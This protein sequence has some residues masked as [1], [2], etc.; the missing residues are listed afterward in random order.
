MKKYLLL[1]LLPFVIYPSNPNEGKKLILKMANS[2]IIIDGIIDNEWSSADSVVNFFQLQP[3]YNQPPSHSTVAKVL[4]TEDAIYCLMICYQQ[5]EDIQANS[6]SLDENTGDIVSF[7]IDSFNDQQ[8]AYKFAVNASGVRMDSRLL[9]DARNRDYSWD[10]I[11]FADSKIYNWGY[12][13]EMK[14]PYKSIKYE[15]NLSEWG[16]DFDRWIPAQNEDLYWC[17]YEQN[18]GQRI[19]KF[20]KLVFENFQPTATG[21]NLEIYPVGLMKVNYQGN[22]KYKVEPDA[23]LDIF[24]NPSQKLT[25]Q[26]TV[27]PDFAQI[28]ADPFDFN[29]SRYESYFNERR[30]FFTEGNEVF[31][32]SGR[33]RNTGFYRP[34][35]LFYSRRIGKLLPDGKRIPLILGTKAFGRVDDWEY[36]GFVAMTS[37]VNYRD[38][39]EE[40]V[41]P[42]AYFGSGRIKKQV[43]GNSSIGLLFVAKQTEDNTYGVID[44]DGAFRESNWQLSYQFARSIENSKGDYAGSAGLTLSTDKWLSYART[45]AIGKNFDVQQ[46]GFVPWKGTFE[47]VSINGP[48]WYY[49]EGYIRQMLVYTG[50]LIYYEDADLFTDY[51]WLFGFNM[52]LR[53]NWGYELNLSFSKSK[54]EGIEYNSY[55]ATFSS[56]YN[57]SPKWDGNLYG[58]YT[59]TYN[60][61]REFLAYYS[62]LGAYIN[63]RAFDFLELGT[64]YDMF[65]EGNPEGNIADITYNARPFI[66]LKPV[67]DL[68]IRVYVDNV[69]SSE[70]DRL[71]SMIVGMLFSWNFLPKSWVYFAFNDFRDRS[72]RFD[73]MGNLLPNK[74][75]VT[76]R[77]SVLKLKY[78]YYF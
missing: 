34:L 22:D 69:Y 37:K 75:H 2:E 70:S 23:G 9:D 31:M 19:S 17:E 46:V 36:G 65:I 54:D 61:S 56:W 40:M 35:E 62:W 76:D 42:R 3:Y 45:R 21:L 4:T 73:S 51:G 63:W 78:L 32:P 7:M 1:F 47:F 8:T 10:G 64:S 25:Y 55:E 27:N 11:W 24:Y 77:A 67:N 58:G 71:E 72:D 74:L 57:I 66:S 20:G 26:L 41:E 13:V 28:E 15:K 50:P 16:L 12:V 38:D 29:I 30:P 14:I 5:K 6:G 18:E 49:D 59:R 60:F 39:D 43:F 33:Q 44:I 68:N 52:Q 53:D 48:I